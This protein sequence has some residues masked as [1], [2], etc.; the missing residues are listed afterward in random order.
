MRVKNKRVYGFGVNDAD[1]VVS[2][3]VNGKQIQ[4]LFYRAWKSMI[5]R[6]YSPT[7][8]KRFPTY[9]GCTVCEEWRTF[10]AFRA[11]MLLQDHEGKDLDKDVWVP[12]NKVYSPET[13]LFL[14]ARVNYFMLDCGASR[15]AYLIGVSFKKES[16]K[17]AAQVCIRPGRN[18]H[19]GYF[20]T[21]IEAHLAWAY[22][23]RNRAY[24]LASEQTDERVARALRN[25]GEMVVTRAESERT[26]RASE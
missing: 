24:E 6:C 9:V 5:F 26:K 17:Y 10:M 16:G 25:F 3:I 8:Q 15:G 23:K 7:Y 13:C 4:C 14:T 22:A 1:Y 11:W 19:L 21:E 18:K 20:T 12:G 2:R